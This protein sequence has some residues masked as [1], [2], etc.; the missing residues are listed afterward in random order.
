[1]HGDKK[2]CAVV[3][4]DIKNTFNSEAKNT[5]GYLRRESSSY[6]S[7][8]LLLYDTNAKMRYQKA[9]ST[10]G[11]PQGSVLDPLL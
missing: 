9:T 5:L 11:V 1:M 8:R 10:N 4:L 6:L 7:D 3:T 2:Y